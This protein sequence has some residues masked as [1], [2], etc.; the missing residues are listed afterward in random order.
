[1]FTHTLQR[2][3]AVA[4]A[5]LSLSAW[6]DTGEFALDTISIEATTISASRSAHVSDLLPVGLVTLDQDDIRDYPAKNT[7]DLLDSIAGVNVRRNYGISGS[8]AYFDLLGFGVT[9]NDNT[10]LLLNGRKINNPDLSATN[11]SAIP[12][13]AIERIEVLPGSGSV[14]YGHGATG[15]VINIVTRDEYETGAGASVTGGEYDT[16]GGR[17]W[18]TAQTGTTGVLGSWQALDSDGF[19][20]N[21]ALRE[22]NTFTDLRHEA[23]NVTY[24]L[25]LLAG[26]ERLGLPGARDVVPGVE[27]EFRDNPDGANDPDNWGRQERLQGMPGIEVRFD[28]DTRLNVDAGVLHKDEETWFANFSQY[29]EVAI[30]SR[31][32]AP[33][34]TGRT[35][36]GSVTHRWT[37]GWEWRDTDSRTATSS[38]PDV[39]VTRS[40]KA[41][42][43]DVSWYLHDVVMLNPKWNLTFGA[44]RTTSEVDHL[45]S[46]DDE[47]DDLEMYQGGVQYR[48]APRVKL[49]GNIERSARLGNFDEIG[50]VNEPLE[51]QTGILASFGAAWSDGSQSSTL[52]IWRGTFEDEIVYDPLSFAN[53]NLPDDTLREGA[54]LNSNW[55][56]DDAWSLTFNVSLQRAR[57]QDGPLEDND[58]PLV[59]ETTM[60]AQIGWQTTPW[61]ELTLAQR[62]VGERY[63]GGDEANEYEPLSSYTWTDLVGRFTWQKAWF[64]V[65]V[66][67]LQ[68]RLVSD[69]GYRSFPPTNYNLYPLP[70]RHVMATA[71]IDF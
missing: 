27:N 16:R 45:A 4:L 24:Y 39:P 29:R 63:F 64:E 58:I 66:Y 53:V 28:D 48:L 59:P 22:R 43:R 69:Y 44:R 52:T 40:G 6:A 14:L 34:L 61:L 62:Y 8:R 38:A 3:G 23:D 65:G 60:Y 46:A 67:N 2:T 11:L 21:N 32:F 15:G 12:V 42:R 25:T 36:T 35:L 55:A 41:S 37:V 26:D 33:R 70:D 1:M 51:P 31:S 49:F 9:G 56:L 17:L 50:F 7:A 30:E 54:S 5:C 71:G 13:S 18:A 57:F 47:K 20:D 19:R 68:D 10:L